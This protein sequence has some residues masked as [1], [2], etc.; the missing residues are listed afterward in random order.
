MNKNKTQVLIL[1]PNE[2]RARV[3]SQVQLSQ[4]ETSDYDQKVGD[5]MESEL[6]LQW[7][8]NAVTKSAIIT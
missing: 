5:M 4:L 6:N 3:S 7:H 1:G 2:E 8:I